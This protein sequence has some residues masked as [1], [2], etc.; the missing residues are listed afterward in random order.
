[1]AVLS[2]LI[3]VTP[4]VDHGSRVRGACLLWTIG[5]LGEE[6]RGARFRGQERRRSCARRERYEVEAERLFEVVLKRLAV[7]GRGG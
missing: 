5:D 4:R 2:G 3:G 7:A 6:I 1:M